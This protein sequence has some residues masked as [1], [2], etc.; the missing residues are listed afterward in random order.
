MIKLQL[1]QSRKIWSFWCIFG[2][3]L[4]KFLLV[5]DLCCFFSY[6]KKVQG[7]HFGHVW[8]IASFIYYTSLWLPNLTNGYLS[9]KIASSNRRMISM[10]FGID[11]FAQPRDTHQDKELWIETNLKHFSKFRMVGFLSCQVKHL[12]NTIKARIFNLQTWSWSRCQFH[13]HYRYEFFVQ[14]SFL[15]VVTFWLCWKICSKNTRI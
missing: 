8:S 10:K 12:V 15:Y 11:A 1:L 14:T 13:Q 3:F 4:T 2:Q 7:P 6:Q 9:K 5:E